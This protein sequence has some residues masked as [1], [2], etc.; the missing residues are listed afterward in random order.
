[1]QRPAVVT[2]AGSGIGE[3][4]A[5]RLA[6]DGHPVALVGRDSG[7]LLRVAQ[8]IAG[9]GG[10]ARALPCDV[11]VEQEVSACVAAVEEAWGVP[12]VLVNNA[13]IGGPFHRIDEVSGEEFDR[14][15]AVNVKG[16]Y[17]FCR[18]LL[19]AMAGQGYGRI[20]NVASIQGFLGSPLS[21][22]YVA[23]KHAVIG[24]TRALAAEWGR[25][26]ITCNAVCPGY[27]E[28]AMGIQ[29]GVDEHQQRVRS[30]TPTGTLARPGEI[31]AM[32]SFLIGQPYING[33][34]QVMDGGI[35]CHAGI[36]DV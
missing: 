27:V 21:S 23:S 20:V 33:S 5:R 2:G 16:L 8:E 3:A 24:Y 13:G 1:M 12:G 22:T 11:A 7:R 34:V 28:T 36:L 15:F 25:S 32:I 26:G 35:S 30:R 19:P 14:I 31:A 29:D 10:T 6:A 18:M 4:T 17:L 9:S